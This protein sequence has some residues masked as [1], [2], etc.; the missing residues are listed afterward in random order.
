MRILLRCAEDMN[1]ESCVQ[2]ILDPDDV[3]PT[4][5]TADDRAD[6]PLQAEKKHKKVRM[7]IELL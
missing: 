6:P 5:P 2:D 3:D 4:D 7:V 1:E